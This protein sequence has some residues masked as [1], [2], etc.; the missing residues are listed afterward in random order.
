[1]VYRGQ[2]VV[3]TLRFIVFCICFLF[4]LLQLFFVDCGEKRNEMYWH[5]YAV[6]AISS[7]LLCIA[8]YCAYE[9]LTI[10]ITFAQIKHTEQ[11]NYIWAQPLKDLH[12]CK[13]IKWKK[14]SNNIKTHRIAPIIV[15]RRKVIKSATRRIESILKEKQKNTKQMYLNTSLG[16]PT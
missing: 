2:I 12:R 8:F 4:F 7:W 5:R 1:M 15:M 3:N 9:I 13:W 10:N 16:T 14:N 11:H 6:E